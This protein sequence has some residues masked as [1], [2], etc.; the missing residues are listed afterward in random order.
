MLNISNSYDK[1]IVAFSG[2]KDSMAC[3]LLLL[4]LGIPK[5]KIELWHHCIDGDG[6]KT[7]MDWECTEDYCRKF[8][9]VFGVKI[10][11]S[12]KEGGFEREMKRDNQKTAPMTFETP[13]GRV[14]VGGTRGKNSTR[15]KFPQVSGDLKT[16]WCSAYLKI[17]VCATAI[18]NQD[19]FNGL[20][21]V[22][23]S[24]ER[25]EESKQRSKYSILEADRSDNRTGK[26]NRYVDRW[27]PIRDWTE[28]EV[29]DIIEKY[30]VV[31]HPCYYMGWSRCSCKFCIFGNADQFLSAFT[32]SPEIGQELVNIEQ[33]FGV[34]LK[35]KESLPQLIEKGTTYST[36]TEELKEI[37][38]SKVYT[39]KILTDNWTL[40]AGAYGES[41][42]PS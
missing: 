10:Y 37:S 1:Y 32:I 21:T 24:G 5:H 16:R 41:C 14:T 13:D 36:I 9:E 25:G 6:T 29:W 28:K 4:D 35:R 15:R 39:G 40:P 33:D 26:K 34:T 42:G 2:G 18:R 8:A 7:L 20:K 11:F 30:K 38:T 27:R 31:V 3:F 12:W 22:V 17:D 19:R 23:L